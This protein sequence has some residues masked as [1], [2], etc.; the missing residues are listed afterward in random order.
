M[1]LFTSVLCAV[2]HTG[3]APRV[4][5][6]A[7]GFAGI[8][9]VPL[10][11]L[12]VATGDTHRE[13]ASI[14]ALI[15]DVIPAGTAYLKPPQVRVM[16]VTQGSAA[17][18]LLEMVSDGTGLLVAGTRARSGLSRWLL[19]STSAAL[20]ARAVCPTLLVPPGDLDIVTLTQEGV[21][22]NV[23]A[24]LAAVDLAE[25]NAT[26]LRLASLLAVRAGQPLVV[27]TVAGDGMNDA[28]V[29]AALRAQSR[30]L[31]TRP[32]D[33]L[34]VRH[35]AIARE[36]AAAA[37]AEPAGLVVMGL[38]GPGHG[39]PGEIATEVLKSRDAL[40]LAVPAERA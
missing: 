1:S 34:V 4:L 40:V 7:A 17:D 18:A 15:Q 24:V 6:H 11:V 27:M 38:R 16:R 22:L 39:T 3:L 32:V 14:E 31:A 8:A 28:D 2:D 37:I 9:G 26:Q 25:P 5:R 33:H 23:G 35:G 29:E 12:S 20:L 10:T 36:I 13:H 19:G 21:R 30:D